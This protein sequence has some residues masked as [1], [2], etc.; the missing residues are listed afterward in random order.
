MSDELRAAA[1]R[2]RR[3]EAGERHKIV[4]GFDGEEMDSFMERM[5][6]NAYTADWKLL[7]KAYLAEHP[8]DDS[9]PADNAYCK[10]ISSRRRRGWPDRYILDEISRDYFLEFDCSPVEESEAEDCMVLMRRL[11]EV[12]EDGIVLI[13]HATR[14]DVR[15]LCAALGV[16]L[17]DGASE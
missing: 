3:V 14:G 1:E 5:L 7:A 2:F 15:R 13:Y 8:A 6:E 17:K 11:P 9:E 4:Y 12:D 16:E 10:K